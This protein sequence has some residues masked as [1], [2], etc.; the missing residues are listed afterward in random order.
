MH[1][2][3]QFIQMVGKPKEVVRLTIPPVAMLQQY[4]LGYYLRQN[5]LQFLSMPKYADTRQV[6]VFRDYSQPGC[7]A[8]PD[9]VVFLYNRPQQSGGKGRFQFKFSSEVLN[10][11]KLQYLTGLFYV[12]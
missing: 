8:I 6:V 4:A 12:T 11:H 3:W 10:D 5:L 9:N 7:P 2:A 1:F